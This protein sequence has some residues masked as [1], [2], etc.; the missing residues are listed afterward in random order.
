MPRELILLKYKIYH[1][2]HSILKDRNEAS[3]YLIYDNSKSSTKLMQQLQSRI[4]HIK[5]FV[6]FYS[7]QI[8]QLNIIEINSLL[9]NSLIS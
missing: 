2:I 1:Q 9:G 4:E 7:L 3:R 5:K 8:H 6:N